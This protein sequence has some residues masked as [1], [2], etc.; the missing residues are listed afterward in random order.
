MRPGLVMR[1]TDGQLEVQAGARA[2]AR[3]S[4]HEPAAEGLGAR[5]P[6]RTVPRRARR[7]A[8]AVVDHVD[9]DARPAA[10]ARVRRSTMADACRRALVTPSA[11]ER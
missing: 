2:A 4:D 8:R 3:R 11:T 6:G 7:A 1:P 5:A 9:A 10:G